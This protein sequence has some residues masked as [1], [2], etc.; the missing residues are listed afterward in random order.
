[1]RG[2][3]RDQVP[4]RVVQ[5]LPKLGHTLRQSA[6]EARDGS[7][8][9]ALAS[10]FEQGLRTWQAA[11]R[12]MRN[13]VAVGASDGRHAGRQLFNSVQRCRAPRGMRMLDAGSGC[14]RHMGK[15]SPLRPQ[16]E[17]PIQ[18]APPTPAA[19]PHPGAIARRQA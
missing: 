13:A 18:P 1:M 9:R 17:P 7:A 12:D 15:R 2:Q 10:L 8:D 19:P 3:V 14:F 5:A 4:E 11:R 6:A 16:T